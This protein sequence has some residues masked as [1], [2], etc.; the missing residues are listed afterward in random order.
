[1][2]SKNVKAFAMAA[3]AGTLFQ[4]G[5]CLNLNQILSWGAWYAAFEFVSDNDTVFD[6][7]EGGA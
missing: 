7:F 2:K 6:L 4:L 1:M 5:G 3:L